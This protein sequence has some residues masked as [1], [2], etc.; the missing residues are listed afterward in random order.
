MVTSLSKKSS[1]VPVKDFHVFFNHQ[2]KNIAH[3]GKSPVGVECIA[4]HLFLSCFM[5]SVSL[6][7]TGSPIR[8]AF[9]T[10]EMPSLAQ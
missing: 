10:M 5:T 6:S 7:G 8:A 2:E 3:R 1:Y 4:I 9:S